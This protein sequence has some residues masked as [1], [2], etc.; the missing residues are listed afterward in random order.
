[1]LTIPQNSPKGLSLA[2]INSHIFNN[3]YP[4]VSYSL[5]LPHSHP[6]APQNHVQNKQ[7]PGETRGN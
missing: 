1:M 7:L 6:S 2:A 3:K 4:L 5:P